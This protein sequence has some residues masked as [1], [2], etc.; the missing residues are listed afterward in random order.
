MSDSV[1]HTD[2]KISESN[3][4]LNSINQALKNRSKMLGRVRSYEANGVTGRGIRTNTFVAP[5]YDLAEIGRATDVE[6]FVLQ[7]IRKH[8]K[9]I[10]KEGYELSGDDQ[11]MVEYVTNRF[12]EISLMTGIPT[13]QWLR[14]LVSTTVQFHNGF[15]ILRRDPTRSTGHK[16]R[17]FGKKLDP[18]AGIFVGDPTSMEVEI[19]RFGTPVKWRQVIFNNLGERDA[20]EFAP[21]DVIHIPI[22]RKPGFTWGTPYL[23]P[24]LDDVRALR[25]LEEVALVVAEKEAF[26]L[27]HYKVGTEEK[28]AMMFEDGTNEVDSVLGAITALPT[29]GYIV[30]S[31]RHEVTLIS[32]DKA[33]MD[34]KPL[35]EYFES[36]V[37][38]GL[39]LSAIDIG[40]G[41]TSNRGTANNL[42]K[43]LEDSA[44]DYQ[45][46]IAAHITQFLIQ[47]LLLEGGYDVTPENQVHFKFPP[48]DAEEMR[49]TQ[50]HG[51]QLMMGNALT[52][53]EYRKHYLNKKPLTDEEHSDTLMAK[54]T[55]AD[56]K[57]AKNTPRATSSTSKSSGKKAA[58][59]TAN[60]T[61]PRNQHGSTTKSRTKKKNDYIEGIKVLAQDLCATLKGSTSDQ[62]SDVLER[63]VRNM[64][65]SA[66]QFMIESIEEGFDR[67]EDQYLERTDNEEVSVEPI[68]QRS[69][70]RFMSNFIVKS[71]WKVINPF[72]TVI[73]D[74]LK[75]DQEGNDRSFM[76][77]KTLDSI[78]TALHRLSIDQLVTAER[79]GFI[80]FARRMG[81]KNIELVDPDSGEPSEHIDIRNVIY[82]DFIPTDHNIAHGLRLPVEQ[83][84]D[85]ED[86]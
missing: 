35:L 44:K 46:Q 79:F 12:F 14:D 42:S 16:T 36:R 55:E 54:Q 9:Q 25:K 24:V 57:L 66:D 51:L 80:K 58:K 28:P 86:L 63:A 38:A 83:E 64:A 13:L 78:K 8:R 7:S 72:K 40:R 67:A 49:T 2:I 34:V 22:D 1:I 15:L 69:I 39:S 10:L 45:Q 73:Y 74:N 3:P 62:I 23:L 85:G 6:P 21:E 70:D 48:I 65:E 52:T 76:L 71:F 17:V 32:R 75:V 33:S 59:S 11:K 41:D 4:L 30:T 61:R 77:V 82:K 29:Q 68:G 47:Q 18:I 5:P 53:S 27:Y 50:A 26:P 19:D 56:I 31:E 60:K 43:N 84:D 37:L 81:Y 20:R